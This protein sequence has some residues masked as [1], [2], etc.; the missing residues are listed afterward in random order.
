MPASAAGKHIPHDIGPCG[1]AQ[2]PHAVQPAH[3]AAGIVQRH[4]VIQT[5]VHAARPKT[6]GHR[7]ETQ[8]PKPG[9]D[10]KSQQRQRCYAHADSRYQPCPQTAGHTLT[11]QAG[12]NGAEGDNHGNQS[13][14]GYAD[15]KLTKHGRP[16]GA[17]QSIRQTK[18]DK[19]QINDCQQQRKHPKSPFSSPRLYQLVCQKARQTPLKRQANTSN[20]KPLY[21]SG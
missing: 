12:S 10:G 20:C 5:G 3:M 7:P 11:H 15:L 2:P 18:A 6:I 19:G 4:I 9:A 14:A 13:G 17:Q 8:H 21:F 16:G 1:S